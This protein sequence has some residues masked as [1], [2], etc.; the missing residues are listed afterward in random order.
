[1]FNNNKSWKLLIAFALVMFFTKAGYGS[2]SVISDDVKSVLFEE[3]IEA[4]AAYIDGMDSPSIEDMSL[5]LYLSENY[6]ISLKNK[7]LMLQQVGF[8]NS[9][10]FKIENIFINN[11]FEENM[12]EVKRLS[13]DNYFMS[14]LL[15]IENIESDIFISNLVSNEYISHQ[16]DYFVDAYKIVTSDE[17]LCDQYFNDFLMYIEI[18]YQ[19]NEKYPCARDNKAYVDR[20]KKFIPAYFSFEEGGDIPRKDFEN[21]YSFFLN[22]NSYFK[23]YF[24]KE[25]CSKIYNTDSFEWKVCN[26]IS[27]AAVNNCLLPYWSILNLRNGWETSNGFNLCRIDFIKE[28]MTRLV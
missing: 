6:E 24:M 5:A 10:S 17:N 18:V 1:M 16:I 23:D 21:G 28:Y 3:G 25:E 8:N 9:D 22:D 11:S 27:N 15:E 20:Y 26:V 12:R 7:G 4:A 14:R 2:S 13:K 19:F